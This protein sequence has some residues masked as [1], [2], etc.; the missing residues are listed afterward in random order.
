MQAISISVGKKNPK[1]NITIDKAIAR[2][3]NPIVIGS[4]RYLR[5]TIEKNDARI[6]KIVDNSRISS[7][8]FSI[9]L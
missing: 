7:L 3:I 4:P 9:K 2:I 1:I 8:L 5:L 6:N